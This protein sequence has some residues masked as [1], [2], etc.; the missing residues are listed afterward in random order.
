MKLIKLFSVVVLFFV[1]NS[2]A[3]NSA[4]EI[5]TKDGIRYLTTSIDYPITGTYLFNGAEPIVELNAGG[6]GFYQVHDQPK[7]AMTWGIEC[8][9]TGEPK[10][11]KGFD[12]AEY[13]LYYKYS[14]TS[15]SELEEDWNKVEFSIH[16]N[17]MKMFVQ[18]ER[19]KSFIGKEEK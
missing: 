11:I 15:T 7:R 1:M 12:N 13:Y 14:D 18:G 6:T 19:V 5:K 3:Q 17:S 2:F 16:F 8:N 10:F 9:E 4:T